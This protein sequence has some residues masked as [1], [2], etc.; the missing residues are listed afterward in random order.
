MAQ[1]Y[2]EPEIECASRNYLRALQS[3]KLVKLVERC[4]EKVPFYRQKFDEIG[5]KPSDIQSIDDIHKLPCT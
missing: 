1:Q 3:A 2:F 5:L 4:Y